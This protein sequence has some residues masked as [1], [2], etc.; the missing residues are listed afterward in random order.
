MIFYFIDYEPKKLLY[1]PVIV[2]KLIIRL[3]PYNH[4]IELQQQSLLVYRVATTYKN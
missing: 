4:K 2:Y 3:Q 1:Q